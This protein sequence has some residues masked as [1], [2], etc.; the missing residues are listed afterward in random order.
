M[1]GL[2]LVAALLVVAGSVGLG[3]P[4]PALAADGEFR[5]AVQPSG[6]KGPT[7]RNHFVYDLPP[8]KRVTDFVGITNLGRKPLTVTLYASDAF[9]SSDGAFA[10]LP[11]SQ[12]PRDV[13]S[14]I[15]MARQAHTIPP[16]R[17]V[18][19]PFTLTVPANASPGDHAG[20][21]LASV[22]ERRTTADGRKVNV[23]RRVAARVYLRVAGPVTPSVTVDAVDV[24]YDDP[25]N[26]FGGGAMTVV[27]RL[28]NSGNVRVNGGARVRVRGPFGVQLEETGTIK[29]PELLPGA[30][31]TLTE[32]LRGVPP[33]GKLGA[34]ITLNPVAAE[35]ALPTA[36]RSGS[37]WAPP[38]TFLVVLLAIAA[39]VVAL[40]VVR[41]R[42]RSAGRAGVAATESV[43]AG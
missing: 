3:A 33:M 25:F 9:S 1:R 34:A 43:P 38:W 31:V 14:W 23:D 29:V 2:S 28:H 21:V 36:S 41:R 40:V 26:P 11:A 18:D 32:R 20:G 10:L 12:R 22:T 5:W 8:G 13:G 39:T 7:G 15:S 17:R 30:Q 37:V 35:G 16:G 4:A 6:P 19:V 42:R 24:A 27:Y